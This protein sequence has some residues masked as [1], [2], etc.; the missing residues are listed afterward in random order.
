M[1]EAP[2]EVSR[3]D[4]VALNVKHSLLV[5]WVLQNGVELDPRLAV[6]HDDDVGLSFAVVSVETLSQ[7]GV[8][9]LT[10]EVSQEED[11]PLLLASDVGNCAKAAVE[12]NDLLELAQLLRD[13][14]K[15]DNNDADEERS[16]V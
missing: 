12:A 1:H 9:G 4:A 2:F 16:C 11:M 13:H 10:V 14:K 6:A 5:G 7:K 3:V 8:Q 15:T